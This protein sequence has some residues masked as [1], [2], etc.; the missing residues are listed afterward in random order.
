MTSKKDWKPFVVSQ[1]EGMGPE[2]FKNYYD[3]LDEK[4]RA[5]V[6]SSIRLYNKEMRLMI[7]KDIQKYQAFQKIVEEAGL[8]SLLKLSERK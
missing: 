6:L 4:G 1:M 5:G 8:T 3:T 2:R 7:T